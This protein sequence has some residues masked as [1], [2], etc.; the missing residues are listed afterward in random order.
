MQAEQLVSSALSFLV[1]Q[2]LGL[3]GGN[4]VTDF[5][6]AIEYTLSEISYFV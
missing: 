3:H 5:Q 2:G 4:Q 1:N 6:Q